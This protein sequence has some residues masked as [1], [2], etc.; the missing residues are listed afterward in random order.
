M[1]FSKIAKVSLA[2]AAVGLLLAGCSNKTATKGKTSK[3]SI[4]LVTNN[5]GVDD[6]SFNQSA[7]QG[8]KAYGKKHDL[9]KGPGGYNYFESSSASDHVP[10]I[11]SAISAH[12]HTIV[13]VGFELTDAIQSEAKKHPKTNFLMIDNVIKAPNVVSATFK[14]QDSS[15]LAGLAAA[16]TTKTNK[17]GFIGGGHNSV[18]NLFDAGF[19]QGVKDAAKAQHKKITIYNTYVGNFTGVDKAKMIAKSMYANGADVVFHAAATAGEGLFQEAKDINQKR[20]ADHKVWAIGVDSDQSQLGAYKDNKGQKENFTLTS[21]MK[22]VNTV[23]EDVAERAYNKKFPG[24]QHLV[25][26]LQHKGTYIL[27]GQISAKAWQAV[28]RARQQI[29]SGKIKVPTTPASAK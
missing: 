18:I 5:T 26:G 7:W 14:S 4:A 29:I 11:E 27:R 23:C 19:T 3:A 9:R 1:H 10:N 8:L 16:Y 25:Y 12:Y 24:G 13:G 2:A 20:S 28:Q 17:V 6:H 21:V 22:G 15:Y